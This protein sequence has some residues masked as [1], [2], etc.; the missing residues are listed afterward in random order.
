MFWKLDEGA[1]CIISLSAFVVATVELIFSVLSSTLDKVVD[2]LF[3]FDVLS[4]NIFSCRCYWLCRARIA[5]TFVGALCRFECRV[6]RLSLTRQ[7]TLVLILE[8]V[9]GG[10]SHGR[11]WGGG[12]GLVRK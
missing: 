8:P 4:N 2:G 7:L 9:N 12:G 10:L 6:S 1:M 11:D 3:L 5:V